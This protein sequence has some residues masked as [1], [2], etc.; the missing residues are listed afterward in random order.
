MVFSLI[1]QDTVI[2]NVILLKKI[3]IQA[4]LTHLETGTTMPL[5]A[6]GSEDQNPSSYATSVP[7]LHFEWFIN[8]KQI[9]SLIGV[10]SKVSF[11][12]L[13]LSCVFL[14]F[15]K[16]EYFMQFCAEG[17]EAPITYG[18]HGF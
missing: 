11:W 1:I 8:N 7:P 3:R 16:D 13:M 14:F 18:R 12:Q 15:K 9:A 2:I 17:N 6:F 5:Y 4:P 10:F